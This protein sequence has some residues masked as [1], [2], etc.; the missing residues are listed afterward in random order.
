MP[1]NG[2]NL[3]Q[4]F[5]IITRGNIPP[6]ST[7]VPDLPEEVSSLV[8][9]MT[10]RER[11][12][13]PQSMQEVAD[14]LGPLAALPLQRFSEPR[15]AV[16]SATDLRPASPAEGTLAGRTNGGVARSVPPRRSTAPVI[17]AATLIFAGAVAAGWLVGPRARPKPPPPQG[18]AAAV[19]PAAG[20][21][22]PSNNPSPPASADAPLPST[23]APPPP[24]ASATAGMTTPSAV[25]HAA[26]AKP[27]RPPSPVA[28]ASASAGPSTTAERPG[29]VYEKTP[30]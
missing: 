25:T 30:F 19:G 15:R 24:P 28:P 20:P 7:L 4:V 8:A 3:G 2:E 5:K 26:K 21:P 11:A 10:T 27:G 1:T 18:V 22:A 17:A 12:A 23:P 6:L 16:T 13:R 29:G 14:V 9:R